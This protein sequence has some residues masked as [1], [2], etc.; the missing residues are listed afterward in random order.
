MSN[1]VNKI[2]NYNQMMSWLTRPATPKTQVADLADDLQPG[3]L[4]DE[5]LN[6]FDPSQETYE[7]Y[8]QRKNLDRPFNAQDGGRAN[9]AIGGG[10]IV[11]EDLGS[12]EGFAGPQ[13]IKTKE[14]KGKYKVRYR[15]EK[16]GKRK[17]GTGFNEGNEIFNTKEEAEK[18]YNNRQ[19]KM[20]EF[21]ASGQKTKILNQTEQI[22]SFVN[23]FFDNNINK[24]GVRDYDKF[25]K[26]LIKNL[27]NLKFHLLEKKEEIF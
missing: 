18:F 27:K 7:E 9:L 15:D 14:N 10:S 11:G 19:A 13:L 23:N 20:S 5:M 1:E 12:R 2:A 25:E 24:Y 22:N 17:S 26:D 6:D 16:F 4:K 21:K 3:P 8:L